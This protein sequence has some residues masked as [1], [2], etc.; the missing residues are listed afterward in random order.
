MTKK[1]IRLSD[2]TDE[3]LMKF[4]DW[5]ANILNELQE[6]NGSTSD[7]VSL[8]I[9]LV[10]QMFVQPFEQ[11][12][13]QNYTKL[14]AQYLGASQQHNSQTLQLL[15][16]IST[17]QKKQYMLQLN[18]F[19]YEDA[20][21][22]KIKNIQSFSDKNS[23]PAIADRQLDYVTGNDIKHLISEKNNKF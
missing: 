9:D 12:N 8:A 16:Q 23:L 17:M 11:D 5:K 21:D 2:S 13:T 22:V 3:K 1:S 4:I 18:Q 14:L 19:S 20:V 6:R 15:K 10:Y 7:A